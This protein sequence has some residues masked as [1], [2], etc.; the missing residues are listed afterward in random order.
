MRDRVEDSMVAVAGTRLE[1]PHHLVVRVVAVLLLGRRHDPVGE[2]ARVRMLEQETPARAIDRTAVP[3]WDRDLR[4]CRAIGR[5][6]VLAKGLALVRELAIVLVRDRASPIVPA[7][8]KESQTDR[9]LLNCQ[10]GCPDLVMAARVHVCPI[11]VPID[12]R[13]WKVGAVIS[14]IG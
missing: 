1:V 5:A 14:A 13:R 7:R 8:D 12:R 2:R 3:E 10:H 11:K 6:S 4:R 9:E